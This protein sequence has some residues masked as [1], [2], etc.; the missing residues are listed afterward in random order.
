MQALAALGK[1]TDAISV[2]DL[3]IPIARKMVYLPLLWRLHGL[4]AQALGQLAK[5]DMAGKEYG[6]AAGII[7]TLAGSIPDGDSRR[8][9]LSDP[10][11]VQILE[12]QAK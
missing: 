1:P 5:K 7:Q 9:F 2:A 12:G 3:A 4:K 8:T 6:E 11:V 10:R